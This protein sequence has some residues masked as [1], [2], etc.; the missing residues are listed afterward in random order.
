MDLQ[1]HMR[2]SGSGRWGARGADATLIVGLVLSVLGLL[3]LLVA[4][5]TTVSTERFLSKCLPAQ[6]TVT[7][8]R[9]VV[10]A[11]THSETYA[12]VF[13][14][15]TKKGQS[16]TIHSGSSSNP[17]GFTVGETVRV[18]YDP[19]KP[20][21]ARIDTLW[22]IWVFPIVFSILGGPLT[23]AGLTL[24][25]LGRSQKRREQQKK[26]DWSITVTEPW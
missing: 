17:P 6:G 7:A 2:K 25:I 1:W 10:D 3:F 22:Q 23:L 16:Y 9:T 11:K 15:T 13:T 5:G 18:L 24:L 8:L 20:T 26:E 19:E 21:D 14:F 12:P 4:A